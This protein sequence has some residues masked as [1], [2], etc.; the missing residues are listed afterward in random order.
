MANEFTPDGHRYGWHFLSGWGIVG[1]Y[2]NKATGFGFNK[3]S[4]V[5]SIRG[6]GLGL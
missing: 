5:V 4:F 6:G 3:V 2:G 1:Y